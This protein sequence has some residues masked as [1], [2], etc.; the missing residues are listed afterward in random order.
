MG[1]SAAAVVTGLHPEWQRSC[2]VCKAAI[3]SGCVTPEVYP[4]A[5][6]KKRLVA[7][8]VQWLVTE[9]RP[10]RHYYEPVGWKLHAVEAKDT[11]TPESIKGY[12]AACGLRARYGWTIDLYIPDEPRN[13]CNRCVRATGGQPW[14]WP[15]SAKKE[16]A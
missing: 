6:H 15:G 4:R 11:D 13:R 3:G 5:S 7:P 9:A 14:R 1:L 2:P 10:D 8:A 16:V 12:R